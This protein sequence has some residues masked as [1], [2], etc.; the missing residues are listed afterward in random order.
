M[1]KTCKN[2]IEWQG[3]NADNAECAITEVD[4]NKDN[5][6][7]SYAPDPTRFCIFCNS[8]AIEN[9]KTGM[10]KCKENNDHFCDSWDMEW[11]DLNK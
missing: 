3:V 1:Q 4:A 2:C 10:L 9:E 6:C 8:E 5:T 7:S 11:I